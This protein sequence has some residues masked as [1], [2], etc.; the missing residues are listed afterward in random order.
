MLSGLSKVSNNDSCILNV[1]ISCPTF[2]LLDADIS[3][4][5]VKMYSFSLIRPSATTTVDLHGLSNIT[6]SEVSSPIQCARLT[7][8]Q[9]CRPKGFL[10]DPES[11]LCQPVFWSVESGSHNF[12]VGNSS[13]Y[14]FDSKSVCKSGF[15]VRHG[16]IVVT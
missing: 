3:A 12:S 15:L 13:L 4:S 7:Y 2:Q 1:F 9:C 14:G 10:Y 5:P 6:W 11:R 8:R 16:Q